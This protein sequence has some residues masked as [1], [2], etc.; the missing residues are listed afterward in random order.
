MSEPNPVTLPSGPASGWRPSALLTASAG[1]HL[2]ALTALIVKPHLW[3]WLVALMLADQG[4][5]AAAGLWPR[6]RLLGANLTRL[7]AEEAADTVALTFDD[8]P[9]PAVTPRVLDL[10]DR[11]G[12]RA[13]FFLIGERARRHPDLVR[14]IV[15]RG[16][17]VENHTYSHP[18]K[19]SLFGPR[20]QARQIDRAQELLTDLAGQPPAFVRA[21]AGLRNVWLDPLLQRRGLRL[22]SW[23]RR[24]LDT[25]DHDADRVTR[26]LLH[27]LRPGDILLLHDGHAARGP[28]GEPMVLEVLPRLLDALEDRG[29]HGRPLPRSPATDR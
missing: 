14:E 3:P 20:A 9:D 27:R 12:A 1:I 10:L 17:R 13:S 28:D 6:S 5:I 24:G 21:P 4:L 22:A 18:L 29:W 8:G 2:V 15:T 16:H 7:R 25:A 11:T 19:F 23:T 26:R